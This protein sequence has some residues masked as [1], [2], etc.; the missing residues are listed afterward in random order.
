MCYRCDACDVLVLGNKPS[1]QVLIEYPGPAKQIGYKD[2]QPVLAPCVRGHKICP[3]CNR[4]LNDPDGPSFHEIRALGDLQKSNDDRAYREKHWLKVEHDRRF[5]NKLQVA[6]RMGV[7][8][9]FAPLA[10]LATK[11]V[12]PAA[13]TSPKEKKPAKRKPV[14]QILKKPKPVRTVTT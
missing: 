2:G 11:T 4:Q 13:V 1:I 12:Q 5:S 10:P 7:A 14:I 8:N 3:G 9:P 6:K